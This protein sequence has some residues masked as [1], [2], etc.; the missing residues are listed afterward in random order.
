MSEQGAATLTRTELCHDLLLLMDLQCQC[1]P[2]HLVL[3]HGLSDADLLLLEQR[4]VH[5]PDSLV[6]AL[7]VLESHEAEATGLVGHLVNHDVR[8]DSTILG[9]SC[10]ECQ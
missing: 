6:Q 1:I 5:L 10:S 9:E 8:G 7:I 3:R 2:W 4:V